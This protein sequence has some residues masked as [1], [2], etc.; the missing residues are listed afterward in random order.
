MTE[1]L[2]L[3]SLRLNSIDVRALSEDGRPLELDARN[4]FPCTLERGL[5]I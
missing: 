4:E 5:S 3:L 1:A 2:V